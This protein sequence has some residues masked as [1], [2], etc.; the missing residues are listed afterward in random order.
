MR[1]TEVYRTA[2]I[3]LAPWFKAEGFGR[4]QSGMLGWCRPFG[5]AFVVFWLQVSQHG[6]DTYAGSEFTAEFRL[7]NVRRIGTGTLRLRLPDFLTHDERKVVRQVRNRVIAG[8][9]EPPRDSYI[10]LEEDVR[11]WYRG[12]FETL[13]TPYKPNEDIWFRCATE[14]DVREWAAFSCWSFP[15]VSAASIGGRGSRARPSHNGAAPAPIVR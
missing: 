2:R 11:R 10:H 4:I 7:S 1:S 14:A 12:E 6:W 9:R 3:V 13:E 15:L 5:D 8:L